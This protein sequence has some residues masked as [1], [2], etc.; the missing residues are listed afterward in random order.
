MKKVLSWILVA[1]PLFYIGL[2]KATNQP[3][4]TLVVVMLLPFIA[5][6]FVFARFLPEDEEKIK[7]GLK[8]VLTTAARVGRPAPGRGG[9]KR[10]GK[11]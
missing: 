7:E 4:E 1:T 9:S 3:V 11:R 6:P 5:A 10:P 2:M 8:N